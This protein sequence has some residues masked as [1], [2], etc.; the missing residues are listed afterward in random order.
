MNINVNEFRWY[1]DFYIDSRSRRCKIP[2][3]LRYSLCD[4]TH[5]FFHYPLSVC[6]II[7]SPHLQ[8]ELRCVD[9]VL[10]GALQLRR[11][12]VMLRDL[13]TSLPWKTMTWYSSATSLDAQTQRCIGCTML[14]RST[15]V[16]HS[17]VRRSIVA[18]PEREHEGHPLF[19]A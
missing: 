3:C 4:I 11:C 13:R 1:F 5:Q 7:K 16:C 6:V 8:F 10:H 17:A 18:A 19:S 15:K 14:S 12:G 2:S 9:Y